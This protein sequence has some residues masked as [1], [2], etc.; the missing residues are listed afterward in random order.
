MELE[1]KLRMQKMKHERKLKS[2]DEFYLNK[3]ET[4]NKKIYLMEQTDHYS[5]Y[6]KA[7]RSNMRQTSLAKDDDSIREV[8][9]IYLLLVN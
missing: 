4:L 8:I 2:S 7:K 1:T 9:N 5:S 3:I 6:N